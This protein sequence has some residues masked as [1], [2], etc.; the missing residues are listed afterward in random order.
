MIKKLITY[1]VNLILDIKQNRYIK[2][3]KTNLKRPLSENDKIDI[4]YLVWSGI[5]PSVEDWF[6]FS[7]AWRKYYWE[8]TQQEKKSLLIN[9]A[10]LVNEPY[11]YLIKNADIPAG[12]KVLLIDQFKT[13]CLRKVR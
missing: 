9:Q 10:S 11:I 3:M 4:E 5:K 1:F 2:T 7:I 13:P 8:I 12:M 6:N